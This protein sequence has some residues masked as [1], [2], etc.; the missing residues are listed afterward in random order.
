MY[1]VK[2]RFTRSG[3]HA[4][5]SEYA[6]ATIGKPGSEGRL[7]CCEGENLWEGCLAAAISS[8]RA[9]VSANRRESR[10]SVPLSVD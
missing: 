3:F 10:I 8:R 4:A 5:H 1:F 7:R 6:V 9:S 2:S